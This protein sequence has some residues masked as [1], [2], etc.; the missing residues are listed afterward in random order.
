[1]AKRM[2]LTGLKK[3]SAG[4][5]QRRRT[6]ASEREAYFVIRQSSSSSRTIGFLFDAP[7]T[8]VLSTWPGDLG[9]FRILTAV[10]NYTFTCTGLV[11]WSTSFPVQ[12]IWAFGLHALV[13]VFVWRRGP[14]RRKPQNAHEVHTFRLWTVFETP[15]R[16]Y[17]LPH[18]MKTFRIKNIKCGKLYCKRPCS[19]LAEPATRVRIP[20]VYSGD[21]GLQQ[22]NIV[23][24]FSG[25]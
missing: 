13:L 2:C 5:R 19:F 25:F 3:Y 10:L 24:I 14:S 7:A 12:C 18:L 15:F 1:M 16:A 22:R 20:F 8:A 6:R 17:N 21:A 4:F 11:T 9:R 23:G